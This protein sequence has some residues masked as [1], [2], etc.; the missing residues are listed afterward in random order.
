MSWMKSVKG[1]HS[2]EMIK[3]YIDKDHQRI[4]SS[5]EAH[6]IQQKAFIQQTKE[7]RDLFTEKQEFFKKCMGVKLD[8]EMKGKAVD[9]RFNKLFK[10]Q[11]ETILRLQGR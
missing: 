7:I 8:V 5:L 1:G 6:K 10:E 11:E 9:D 4:T 2:S 3:N